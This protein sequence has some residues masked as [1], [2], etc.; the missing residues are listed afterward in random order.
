M[1]AD[2]VVYH[3]AVAHYLRYV[4]TTGTPVDVLIEPVLTLTA[5]VRFVHHTVGSWKINWLTPFVL[6][7]SWSR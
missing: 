7:H 2:A 1:V 4:A 3:P 5:S 6:L